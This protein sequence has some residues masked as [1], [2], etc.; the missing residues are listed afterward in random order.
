MSLFPE[1]A[2]NTLA[3]GLGRAGVVLITIFTTAAL[4][5]ILGVSSYGAYVFVIALL[6]LFVSIA[7]WG[8]TL[9]FVRESVKNKGAEE[10][11]YGNA[12][13]FRS[14]L[15]MGTLVLINFLALFPIF[16]PLSFPI[17][18]ASVLLILISLK[19]TCHVIFQ[20]K[21][22]F[23]YMALID[24]VISLTFLA[25]LGLV[26]ILFGLV[27]TL[28]GILLAFVI[29][30]L[31][32]TIV[33][34]SLALSLA[35][36]NF[37]F[38]RAIMKK[39]ALEAI[40][41]GALLLIFSIYNRLDIF[42][43][44]ILRGS[45]PVGIYG[46]AYKVHDN[47][48]LG[49]AY[50]AAALFPVISSLVAKPGFQNELRTIYRKIFDI[51]LITGLF[52][53]ISVFF[54]APIIILIIGGVEFEQSVL[55]LRILVFGTFLAYF[56]HLTGYTLVALG[57]QRV[58]LMVAVIALVWN[59]SL[60]LILIPRYSYVAAAV[61]TI[62]TEGLVLVLTSFYL[63][64]KFSLQPSFTFPKTLIELIK[65]RGKIF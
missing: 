56:N 27:P 22:K 33:A 49:S 3:Q 37:K 53:L 58:S 2:K 60:N 54:L 38:N 51:L 59:L 42:L 14:L 55:A 5:R 29:A 63:A 1:V 40:P 19:T 52:V 9:I 13:I 34:F 46:L 20:T 26:F 25:L 18:I 30:N 23:E 36:I 44:Q 28:S 4:T 50:L 24:V 57:K 11:F 45:E 41:T 39:I 62:T 65:T 21:S 12:F 16:L 43:L 8:T 6:M 32:G 31:L 47:L 7:D 17:K 64:R 61:V 35:K 15:A 10:K 48:I